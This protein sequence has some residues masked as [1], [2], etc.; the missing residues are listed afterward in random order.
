MDDTSFVVG[1]VIEWTEAHSAFAARARRSRQWQD[2]MTCGGSMQACSEFEDF[3]D[4]Q[5]P[6]RLSSR[7]RGRTEDSYEDENDEDRCTIS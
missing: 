1:E 5:A 6:H 4:A 2:L 3:D 7:S